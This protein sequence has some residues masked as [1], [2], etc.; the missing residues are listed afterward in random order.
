[1]KRDPHAD[2]GLGTPR[3]RVPTGPSGAQSSRVG[4][5][6]DAVD[7]ILRD[8]RTLRLRSPRHSDRG[9]LTAFLAALSPASMSSRFHAAVRPRGE[10]IEQYLDPDWRGRGALI[11][12]LAGPAGGRV[13]ALGSYDRLRDPA[14]AEV[15]LA[16][17]DDLQG[18]GIGTRLLEQLA[19]RAAE[20]GIARLMLEIQ[21]GNVPMIGV[22]RDAGFPFASTTRGGVIEM[23]VQIGGTGVRSDRQDEHD[24][25][26]VVASLT[27]FLAPESVAVYGA[28]ARRGTVGG[29]LFHNLRKA[30]F[31]GRLYPVNRSGAAVDGVPA[32]ATLAGADGPVDLAVICVPGDSVLDAV[33]DA[34]ASGVRAICVVSAGFAEAGG[35]GADRQDALLALV[36]AYGARL[37]GPNC[38]GVFSASHCVDA[39]FAAH[40]PLAGSVGFASQSGALGLAVVEQA[41][42]RGLGLSAFVSLG[43]KADVSSNDLLEYWEDDPAT[44]VI[45]LY[46]E[47]FGN[48]ERFGRIARRVARTKP[49]LAL[50]G[51][52]TPAGARAAA[53]HTA[54]LASSG[55]A[56]DALFRQAGVLRAQTLS[57]FLDAALMLSTQP[58]PA[59]PRVAV[60]T[61]GGGLGILFADACAAAG[62]ELPEPSPA[63]H[64]LLASA[65]P[66]EG[67]IGNPVDLLGSASAETFAATLGPLLAASEFDAVCVLFAQPAFTAAGDVIAALEHAVATAPERKPVVA[68]LL[69]EEQTD[70]RPSI[71]G[72]T[73]FS[74]PEAA[75]SA[76]GFAARRTAWLRRPHGVVPD[77]R[78]V[79]RAAGR[80]VVEGALEGAA[81]AWLDADQSSRLLDAYGIPL[82]RG[83]VAGSPEEAAAA[84]TVLGGPVAVKSALPGAHKTET[85]GV[86][87]NLVGSEEAGAAAERIGGPVLVQPMIEGVELIAGIA[88]D[89]TFGP[90]VALGLGG[91]FT[92]LLGLTSLAVAPLTDVDA[93]DMVTAG[94]VGRLA[95]G[96]RGMPPLDQRAL[97][98]LLHRLSALAVDIPEVVELDLNPVLARADGCTAVDQRIRVRRVGGGRRLK[99]W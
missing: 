70:V 28:S 74:S 75:A 66:A 55:A 43:N 25:V 69:S 68:V 38:L 15:A 40:A 36:R 97:T 79:D 27:R 20:N 63:T 82:A 42:G 67:S 56:T 71:D 41:R 89:V 1:M 61:N 72:V 32:R 65:T 37:V 53:S 96:F 13:V 99:S 93:G 6:L 34:L 47:S 83:I 60:V 2:V 46:L 91:V 86:A 90:L 33:A 59:G 21:T 19:G 31:S 29:E 49:V 98:D 10:L 9:D 44:S 24:H 62:L 8:G 12:E 57:E 76:L 87:L 5:P 14:G 3:D 22:V 95:A 4:L 23:T 54:A 64:A 58:L 30:G 80:A 52:T 77:L 39:T 78:N 50:K 17:A 94:P 18:I 85:G 11:A 48:P 45:A 7:V 26:A 16:V 84:A 88:R 73:L 92:E 81:E 51:G 35:E